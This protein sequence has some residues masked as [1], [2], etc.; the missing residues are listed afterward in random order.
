[1]IK[2]RAMFDVE[3]FADG[4][5]CVSTLGNHL[6]TIEQQFRFLFCWNEHATIIASGRNDTRGRMLSIVNS[7]DLQ[8]EQA[9]R[10]VESIR[11]QLVYHNNLC[12]RIQSLQWPVDDPVNR[13]AL[14]ARN[15]LQDL[16]TAARYAGMKTGIGKP[17]AENAEPREEH[18]GEKS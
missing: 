11:R 1:M 16:L 15:A 8:P 4:G 5:K 12:A 6:G 10:L 3:H 7:S 2:I 9:A 18:E 17:H 14:V 13:A